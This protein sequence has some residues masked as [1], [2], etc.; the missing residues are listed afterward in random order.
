MTATPST[1]TGLS[2]VKLA[3]LARQVRAQSQALLGADPIAIVGM[4]C[5]V[6]GGDT[7]EQ[8]WQLLRNGTDA[9]VTVPADRWDAAAWFDP[10]LSAI[11]KSVTKQGGFLKQIDGFDAGYFGIVPREA[12]RMDPQ[13]RLFLEV[14]IEALDEAGQTRDRLRGS[15]TG[16]FVASYHNDYTHQQY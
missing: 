13:Q 9:V 14:A 5:R 16:V 11:G 1:L 7:P 4:A 8:F 15:R 2:A 6:P 12:Q 3:L 10:D